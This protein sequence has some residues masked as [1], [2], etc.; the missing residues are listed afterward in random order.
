MEKQSENT[1]YNAPASENGHF[2]KS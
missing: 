2:K 1:G